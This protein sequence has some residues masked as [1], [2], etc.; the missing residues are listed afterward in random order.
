MAVTA[1]V[2]ADAVAAVAAAVASGFAVLP[3]G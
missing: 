1:Q 3:P 2:L